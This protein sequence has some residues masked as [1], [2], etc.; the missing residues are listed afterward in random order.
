MILSWNTIQV[1]F[2]R[3]CIKLTISATLKKMNKLLK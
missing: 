1:P 3:I 2:R